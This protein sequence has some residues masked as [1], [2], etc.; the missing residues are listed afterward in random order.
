MDCCTGT[1][2]RAGPADA[3]GRSGRSGPH[4]RRRCG[5]RGFPQRRLRVTVGHDHANGRRGQ[6]ANSTADTPNVSES[7][8]ANMGIE[9]LR[10]H[11]R[12]AGIDGADELHKPELLAKVKDWHY[13][14][15]HGGQQRG[16]ANSTGR[17]ERRE[18]PRHGRGGKH[19]AE[20]QPDRRH[21]GRERVR[22][23]RYE[24]RR[25][26]RARPQARYRRRR[27]AAQARATGQGEG[28]ALHPGPQRAAPA[29][30]HA[31]SWVTPKDAGRAAGGGFAA[32]HA[33][34]GRLL[35]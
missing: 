26:A 24:D 1:Q 3:E 15:A 34:A 29:G 5:P 7:D 11:A 6:V 32:R 30:H 33:A 12:T 10:E 28:P 18:R 9:Q 19:W 22:A 13:A 25:A 21:A 4:R 35:G 20:R 27:P 31:V 17:G 16:D 2:P 8:L 14:Q 23:C